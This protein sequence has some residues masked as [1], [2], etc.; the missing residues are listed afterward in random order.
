[1]RRARSFR[2]AFGSTEAIFI[3]HHLPRFLFWDRLLLDAVSR[4]GGRFFRAWASRPFSHRASRVRRPSSCSRARRRSCRFVW[5]AL[6]IDVVRRALSVRPM[7]A[8]GAAS[9][10]LYLLHQFIGVAL[11]REVGV[12]IGVRGAVVAALMAMTAMV[13]YPK[14]GDAA[15][16]THS[17]LLCSSM[18]VPQGTVQSAP[19]LRDKRRWV[20]TT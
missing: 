1:M 10:S 16:S 20:R 12:D 4:S 19:L 18:L 17:R 9:Y 8:V 3:A 6:R 11:I 15:Q 2:I 7:A 5:A 13:L 14:L